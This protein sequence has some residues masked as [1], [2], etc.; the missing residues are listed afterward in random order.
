M[1]AS[2][3]ANCAVPEEGLRASCL[4][5][6][7]H[8][9]T[10][11]I[12]EDKPQLARGFSPK[13][14]RL[15][16]RIN[17]DIEEA[18]LA[19]I[20]RSG[21]MALS[22]DISSN[23]HVTKLDFRHVCFGPEEGSILA[24]GLAT[25]R[26]LLDLN[27]QHN[28]LSDVGTLAVAQA[29]TEQGVLEALTLDANGIGDVGAYAIAEYVAASR[30]LKELRLFDNHI[31]KDGGVAIGNAVAKCPTLRHLDLG[32]NEIGDPGAVAV[33][34]ALCDYNKASAPTELPVLVARH[35]PRHFGRTA[36]CDRWTCASIVSGM[37]L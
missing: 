3:D 9:A 17:E 37:M 18:S 24:A 16:V 4:F 20:S 2:V 1:Y 35:W 22:N 25:N 31:L 28:N 12:C 30:T 29:L 32:L 21:L 13:V 33:A 6:T 7:R 26:V 15:N 27:L 11:M 10:R 19:N 34:T 5:A 8:W 23:G 14:V 36:N